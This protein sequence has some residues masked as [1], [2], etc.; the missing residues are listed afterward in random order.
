MPFKPNG[1]WLAGRMLKMLIFYLFFT[2]L[3]KLFFQH[4]FLQIAMAGR[5]YIIYNPQVAAHFTNG[6]V[7]QVYN[8]F[9]NI[10]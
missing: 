9:G 10:I 6:A 8:I 2:I 5:L 7:L 1:Y 4:C 3:G